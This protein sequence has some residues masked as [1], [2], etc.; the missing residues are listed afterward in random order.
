M[1]PIPHAHPGEVE[2]CYDAFCTRIT[3]SERNA[4]IIGCGVFGA[5]LGGIFGTSERDVV[6]G[7]VLGAL[8]GALAT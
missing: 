2:L 8:L 1:K 7:G 6:A 3:R 5:I 4:A